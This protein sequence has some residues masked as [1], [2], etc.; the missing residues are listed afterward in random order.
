MVLTSFG[1]VL[2]CSALPSGDRQCIFYNAAMS[3]CPEAVCRPRH[4]LFTL[5]R[6]L[7]VNLSDNR[8]RWNNL[9]YPH[10]SHIQVK[11]KLN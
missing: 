9:D 11:F 1:L 10:T 5:S 4:L 2:L 3:R 7:H 6:T 8:L